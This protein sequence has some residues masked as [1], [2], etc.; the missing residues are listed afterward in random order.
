MFYTASSTTLMDSLHDT[1]AA[2]QAPSSKRDLKARSLR[3]RVCPRCQAS[4]VTRASTRGRF[5]GCSSFPSCR[6]STAF[7]EDDEILLSASTKDRTY[8][9]PIF[10]NIPAGSRL[11]VTTER[12]TIAG[13]VV[14]FTRFAYVSGS[15]SKPAD[16]RKVAAAKMS[17]SKQP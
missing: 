1:A 2:P 13:R 12:R 9:D 7:T 11:Q 8:R 3:G 17:G 10:R 14:P 15:S 4:L 16:S 6:F 5:W